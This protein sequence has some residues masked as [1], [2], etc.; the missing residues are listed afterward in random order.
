MVMGRRHG[1]ARSSWP[2]AA[3]D[4]VGLAGQLTLALGRVPFRRPW[5]AEGNLPHNVAVAVTRETIRSF[6]GYLT[7]LPVDEFRSI[8][9]VLDD[10][11]GTLLMYD[12]LG[13]GFHRITL[14]RDPD[15]PTCGRRP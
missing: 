14:P 13:A 10:L 3:T 2:I 9:L 7:A 8:E 6:M 4:L 11:S 1:V 15:C 12:A 5:S